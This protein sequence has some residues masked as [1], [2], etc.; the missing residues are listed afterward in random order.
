MHTLCTHT[1][2]LPP[3][4]TVATICEN[5]EILYDYNKLLK[6]TVQCLSMECLN[7]PHPTDCKICCLNVTV[8]N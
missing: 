5:K 4:K 3:T 2:E 8:F 1:W 7:M 6:D